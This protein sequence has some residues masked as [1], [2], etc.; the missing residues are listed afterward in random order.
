MT[1]ATLALTLASVLAIAG[2][3]VLFKLA[4]RATAAS[5]AGFPWDFLN[6]WFFAALVVY[7][8]A[9]LMW[10]WVLK[11]VPLNIAYPFVGLA[12]IVVPVLAWMLLNE[13]LDWRHLAGGALIMSGVIIASWR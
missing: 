8:V 6:G 12:F 13:S 2:G 4:A 1:L 5:T 3:Q 7:G 10:V 9:T 11:T